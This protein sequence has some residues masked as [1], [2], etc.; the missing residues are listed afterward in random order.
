MSGSINQS[1]R[2]SRVIIVAALSTAPT[3][4][5]CDG[6][7]LGAMSEAARRGEAAFGEQCAMCHD[8]EA[9]G[10]PLEGIVGRQAGTGA[11]PYSRALRESDVVWDRESLERFLVTPRETIPGN[12]MVFYG[13]DDESIVS[14]I[15]AYLE[16]ISQ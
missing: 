12:Q 1:R 13:I 5:G 15:I 16:Y 7:G 9:A 6:A 3:L 14:D 8:L 11:F 2:P 10:P 4:G